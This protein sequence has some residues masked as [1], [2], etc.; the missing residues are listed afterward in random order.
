M[1]MEKLRN[2]IVRFMQKRIF[3]I[4]LFIVAALD[5]FAA[6]DAMSAWRAG[7]KVQYKEVVDYGIDKCFMATAIPDKVFARMKGKTYK[8][9]CTVRRADLRY[10]RVLHYNLRGEIC[11]GELVCDKGISGDLVDIF[12]KLFN[13]KYPIERMVLIDNYGADDKC[14]M[15]ANNTSCFNYRFVAGSKVL[16]NHSRGRAVDIN[17]LYNPCVAKRRNGTVSVDPEKGWRYADRSKSFSYKIEKGD[18]C[19]RLFIEHGFT[20]GGNWRTKKDYQHFEKK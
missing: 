15:E 20:W 16:S 12:R 9:N 11:I 14:S 1:E 17:P 6:N 19:Y 2:T 18:L 13:A 7:E 3:I 10:V 4:I 5:I 8:K